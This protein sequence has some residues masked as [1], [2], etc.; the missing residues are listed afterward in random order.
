M[1]PELLSLE[2]K[3]TLLQLARQAISLAVNNKPL[4]PI[5]ENCVTALL[6]LDGASFVTLTKDGELRGCVGALEP[7]MPLIEDVR[8]HAVA[9]ALQDY[10]FPPV[11]PDEISRIEIEI[12]RL[13][14][15]QP[16]KY[17]EP[18]DLIS[19]LR[20]NIDGVIL[21]DGYRKATFL[22]QVWE[23][24][25]DPE[26]FLSHLCMKM[27]ASP[28]LWQRRKLEVLIYQVEEFHEKPRKS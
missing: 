4:P 17:D 18:D 25:P 20:P 10:R 19:R 27:G 15:P 23:K 22:P 7:A 5:D 21:M 2:E 13:T 1:M 28:N 6:G 11:R 14:V 9:A 16:L 26:E 24:L 12:S 8:Y 3:E